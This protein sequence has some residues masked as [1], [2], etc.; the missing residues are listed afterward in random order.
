MKATGIVRKLDQIGRIVIPME[1][2][3]TLDINIKDS[4][5]IFLDED[6]IVLQKYKPD[7]ACMVTGEVSNDNFKLADG[8]II[9]SRE[10]AE[11]LLK[12]MEQLLAL[13]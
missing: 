3:R 1:L 9:L 11:K 6:C 5:E 2:R 13:N 10:G 4:L 7:M 8:K 12:E